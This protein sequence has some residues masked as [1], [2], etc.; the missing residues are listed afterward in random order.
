ME[1]GQKLWF[2]LCYIFIEQKIRAHTFNSLSE[3]S[4]QS[5]HNGGPGEM[6]KNN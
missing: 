2:W 5:K 1:R 6:D 4:G 3:K